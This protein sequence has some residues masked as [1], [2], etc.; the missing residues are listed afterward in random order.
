MQNVVLSHSNRPQKLLGPQ[1]K[2]PVVIIPID[3]GALFH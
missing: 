3:G 2:T 1:T